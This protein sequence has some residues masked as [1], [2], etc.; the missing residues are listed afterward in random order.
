[1]LN[2][3]I[4]QQRI[5]ICIIDRKKY[6]SNVNEYLLNLKIMDIGN[7]YVHSLGRLMYRYAKGELPVLLYKLLTLHKH[8]S[9]LVTTSKHLYCGQLC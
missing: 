5:A 6:K 4:I 3:L 2:P 1:M 9:D 7:L 8:V